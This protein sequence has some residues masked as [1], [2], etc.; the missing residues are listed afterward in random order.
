MGEK[1]GT[2]LWKVWKAKIHPHTNRE[3]HSG[4]FQRDL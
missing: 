4:F 3:A 1:A 2:R